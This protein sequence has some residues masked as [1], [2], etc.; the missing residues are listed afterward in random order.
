MNIFLLMKFLANQ[1]L[2]MHFSF[3]Y[4]NLRKTPGLSYQKDQNYSSQL[5]YC[6]M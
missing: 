6:I 1:H 4:V 5:R 3:Y 2:Q